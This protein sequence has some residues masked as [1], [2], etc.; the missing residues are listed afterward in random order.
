MHIPAFVLYSTF[1]SLLPINALAFSPTANNNIA[2]YWGQNSAGGYNTQQRLSYYCQSSSSDIILL[3]FLTQFFSTGG[4]PVLNFASACEGTVFPGTN[5]LKCDQI[6]EDIKTCQSLGKKVLLSLGGASGAYGFTS[7]DQA[8][9]FATTLW[10]VFGNGESDTRPFGDAI[11]DGYDLDIEGGSPLYY[12]NFVKALRAKYA[13]DPSRQYYVSAAPQCPI[14][15][16]YVNDAIVNSDLDF[17]F[18][19]FYNNYCGLQAI[20]TANFNF[21]AWHQLATTKSQNPHVKVYLGVPASQTAAGSGYADAATVAKLAKELQSKFSSF[22]GV[23]MWDASQAWAN[24]DFAGVVKQ[25]IQSGVS[26]RAESQSSGVL[27]AP[28]ESTVKPLTTSSNMATPS[29]TFDEVKSSGSVISWEVI[30]TVWTSGNQWWTQ[31]YTITTSKPMYADYFSKVAPTTHATLGTQSS[32]I[33]QASP[34]IQASAQTEVSYETQASSDP[35]Q[36]NVPVESWKILTTTSTSKG[37]WWTQ[38]YTFTQTVSIGS[39]SRTEVVPITSQTIQPSKSVGSWQVLTTTFTSRGEWWTQEYIFTSSLPIYGD[40]PQLNIN[41][42]PEHTPEVSSVSNSISE[43]TSWTITTQSETGKPSPDVASLLAGFDAS[44]MFVSSTVSS[45]LGADRFLS[46]TSSWSTVAPKEEL[47]PDVERPKGSVFYTSPVPLASL[48]AMQLPPDIIETPLVSLSSLSSTPS[49]SSSIEETN[50]ME[51]ANYIIFE[52]AVSS[53]TGSVEVSSSEAP[54]KFASLSS[55]FTQSDLTP[56]EP[57][58][59]TLREEI[60]TPSTTS[61]NLAGKATSAAD[62]S[63]STA[64][65]GADSKSDLQTS[66]AEMAVIYSGV[67]SIPQAAVSRYAESSAGVGVTSDVKAKESIP[68]MPATMLPAGD[69][70]DSIVQ[71]LTAALEEHLRSTSISANNANVLISRSFVLPSQSTS[72]SE[73]LQMLSTTLKNS[74]PTTTSRRATSQADQSWTPTTPIVV[75]SL[76]IADDAVDDYPAPA[77]ETTPAMAVGSLETPAIAAESTN[78]LCPLSPTATVT[79]TVTAA[80][81]TPT[82]LAFDAAPSSLQLNEA[83]S[84]EPCDGSVTVKCGGDVLLLCDNGRWAAQACGPG[85]A[86]RSVGVLAFCGYPHIDYTKL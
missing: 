85:T 7:S 42:I 24:N 8:E 22:G 14:P 51:A 68:S 23:M 46:S 6:A 39:S 38:E 67:K 28:K 5:L 61:I 84:G 54:A 20:N 34:A 69:E 57:A 62:T 50:V 77:P 12:S 58:E 72:V 17:L 52:T 66:S 56:L 71:T 16:A 11:I 13:T 64:N 31:S 43:P 3:S 59:F 86:C 32:P 40:T 53:M 36:P 75:P 73:V 82:I 25:A 70:E 47:A 26:F 83:V 74:S 55:T 80:A 1:F 41:T 45:F 76:S 21:D 49:F 81:A 37:Q 27:P 10:N 9:E 4:L 18:V 79:V 19:Q 35:A 78:T 15:D 63:T 30:T 60:T 65:L 44:S 29:L 2:L 48:A 33:A